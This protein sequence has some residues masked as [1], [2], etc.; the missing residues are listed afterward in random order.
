[1]RFIAPIPD[2]IFLD[3]ASAWFFH[4][5]FSSISTPRD[6]RMFYRKDMFLFY[7][8][9]EGREGRLLSFFLKPINMNP[10]LVIVSVNSFAISQRFMLRKSSLRED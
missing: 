4:T 7:L 6:L 1:M 10:V 5:R 2:A 8:F 9:K 3:K